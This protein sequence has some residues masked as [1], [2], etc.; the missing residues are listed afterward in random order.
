LSKVALELQI[1][2]ALIQT[3]ST[4]SLLGLQAQR[5]QH[6]LYTGVHLPVGTHGPAHDEQ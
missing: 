4:E 5:V 2:L 6:L 1:D 3:V